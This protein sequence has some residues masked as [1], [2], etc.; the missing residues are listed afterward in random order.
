MNDKLNRT[1]TDTYEKM[2]PRVPWWMWIIIIVCMLPGLAFPAMVSLITDPNP[3]VKGLVWFYPFYVL[4][5]GF[6]A[7][8]CYERRTAMSWIILV[9]LLLS[10]ACF[11]YMTFYTIEGVV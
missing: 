2:L 8:Q 6:L 7:W 11:Y 9:L 3:I 5:S 4:M 10:H 1:T